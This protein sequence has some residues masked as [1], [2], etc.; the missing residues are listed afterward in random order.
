MSIGQTILDDASDHRHVLVDVHLAIHNR[1][2]GENGLAI[3][4]GDAKTIK[5]IDGALHHPRD[6]G[7][8]RV[9][10]GHLVGTGQQPAFHIPPGFRGQANG[11]CVSK[12][13]IDL[14]FRDTHDVDDALLD[15][16]FL[17]SRL[18]SNRRIEAVRFI[19]QRGERASGIHLQLQP[20]GTGADG[21]RR[22]VV[23]KLADKRTDRLNNTRIHER[24]ADIAT[25]RV[26][27]DRHLD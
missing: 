16:R 9:F 13:G 7:R 20:V 1:G 3:R 19:Q 11:F 15:F 2:L 27:S 8:R 14:S 25:G 23:L 5:L 22:T 17:L 18:D 21:R 26:L 4:G 12:S 6:D 10:L 24:L